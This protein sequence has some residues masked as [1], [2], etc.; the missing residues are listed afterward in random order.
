M[1]FFWW[2]EVAYLSITCSTSQSVHL[3][4]KMVDLLTGRLGSWAVH[5]GMKRVDLLTGRLGNWVDWETNISESTNQPVHL[6]M[7]MVDLLTGRLG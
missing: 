3:G 5:L 7:R 4:M 1:C 2:E 6:G